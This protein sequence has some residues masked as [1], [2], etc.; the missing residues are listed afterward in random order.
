MSQQFEGDYSLN[1][2]KL[3]PVVK[4]GYGDA[5]DIKELIG[6]IT[7]KESILSA[8]LYCSVVVKDIDQNLIGSLP[9]MGQEK[10]EIK[11]SAGESA[12]TLNFYVYSID[13][14]TMQEKNQAYILHCCSL[15]ALLNESRR[16]SERLDGVKSEEF[17]EEKI[18]EISNKKFFKDPS[19]HNFNMYVPNWR[20]FD[21]AVWFRTRTVATEHKDSIGYLFWEGF[22]GYHFK[23][24]DTLIKK[25]PYPNTNKKYSFAQGNTPSSGDKFRITKYA[26]PKAFNVFD[27]ARSG[28]FS[29]D[30]CYLDINHRTY[31]IFRT[32][33][34]DFWEESQHLGDLKPYRSDGPVDFSKGAGRMIYRP[35]TINTFGTWK[36]DQ[37]LDDTDNVDEANKMY[38]KAIYRFYFLEYN[39]LDVAVP[40]DLDV[41]AGN[42][43]SITMPSPSKSDSGDIRSD[44]RLS[45]KYLVNSVTHTLNRDKLSTR[46]TL[47][48]DSFGGKTITDS[49]SETQQVNIGQ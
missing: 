11:V 29:H 18:A 17:L 49:K 27:D 47:T 2:I 20:L 19:L 32:T 37:P 35:T 7:L 22:D 31:R 39:K 8:S 36:S 48:R 46:I 13:G 21:T 30:A 28:S 44:S 15:E 12:W 14:R 16:I 6:E 23:S 5:I 26:S 24:I 10:I 42:I 1:S 40:G 4:N 33:A 3:Y 25:T 41:R 9:L 45:G 38:E 43:I 34:D